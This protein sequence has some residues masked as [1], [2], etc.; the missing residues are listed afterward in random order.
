[1]NRRQLGNKGEEFVCARLLASGIDILARNFYC[2][3]GEIDI[4]G[5]FGGTIAFVEVKTRSSKGFGT[6][7]EAVTP[8]K[9]AKIKAAALAYI[10]QN[11]LHDMNFRFDVAEVYSAKGGLELNYIKSAFE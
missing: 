9:Q 10:S 4:I 3:A 7:A 6:A 2:R 8:A 11:D 5:K 1:M